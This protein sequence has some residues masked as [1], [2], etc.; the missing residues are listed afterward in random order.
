MDLWD[1]RVALDRWSARGLIT[2]DQAAAIDDFETVKTGPVVTGSADPPRWGASVVLAYAGVLVALAAVLALYMTLFPDVTDVTRVGL[3]VAMAVAAAVLG[4]LATRMSG[5]DRIADA[6]GFSFALL[7]AVAGLVACDALDWID[8][9]RFDGY[10]STRVSLVLAATAMGSAAWVSVRW[11][12]SPLAAAPLILA[13]IAVLGVMA[14]SLVN[15][16]DDQPGRFAGMIVTYAAYTLAALQLVCRLPAVLGIQDSAR[17]WATLAA[18]GASNIVAFTLAAE[19][20]GVHEG[21]LL[22]HAGLQLAVAVWR[23]GRAWLV[24]GALSLY[25]FIGFVVFRTFDGAEAAIVVLMVVGLGTA[26][27]ALAGKRVSNALRTLEWIR[28]GGE[29]A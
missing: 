3:A 1:L 29:R 7:V 16:G 14:W 27:S 28:G 2:P 5:G 23:G 20:G 22:L 18:L 13:P 17:G 9:D 19:F 25:E 6:L 4:M 12:Q 24:F 10:G 8:G 11:L 15:P 26:F 21:L